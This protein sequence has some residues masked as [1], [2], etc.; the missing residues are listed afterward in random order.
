MQSH[1]YLI[2]HEPKFLLLLTYLPYR[3][4]CG[5]N[6]VM[7]DVNRLLLDNADC[8]SSGVKLVAPLTSSWAYDKGFGIKVSSGDN[9]SN[10]AIDLIFIS[11]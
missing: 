3:S 9:K 8:F 11:P 10:E 5:V 6:V 4:D 7:F 1:Y 2:A